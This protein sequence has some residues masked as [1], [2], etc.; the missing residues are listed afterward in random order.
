VRQLVHQRSCTRRGERVTWLRCSG[1]N[2]VPEPVQSHICRDSPAQWHG[3]PGVVVNSRVSVSGHQ[4]GIIGGGCTYIERQRCHN[5][6]GKSSS[7]RFG[8]HERCIY[9]IPRLEAI[10]LTRNRAGCSKRPLRGAM[11][12]G[13]QMDQ[14]YI[15][16]LE[17]QMI[18]PSAPAPG[19]TADTW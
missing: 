10:Q 18:A 16:V 14:R 12:S 19:V 9:F 5:R 3:L 11:Q 6:P 17:P 7:Q 13:Q 2:R 4:R 15:F 1:R 8:A